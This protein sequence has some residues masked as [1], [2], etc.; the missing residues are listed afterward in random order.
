[1]L[2]LLFLI[3]N[4]LWIYL[5]GIPPK[6]VI[7]IRKWWATA[8]F[9]VPC[10]SNFRQTQVYIAFPLSIDFHLEPPRKKR[11][12]GALEE[13]WLKMGV[14]PQMAILIGK[15]CLNHQNLGAPL[16]RQTHMVHSG[17]P[18]LLHLAWWGWAA[19]C[20]KQ[21]NLQSIWGCPKLILV[22]LRTHAYM[23]SWIYRGVSYWCIL[24]VTPLNF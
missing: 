20:L 3:T 13:E 23:G 1:M 22:P 4:M 24:R 11:M 2:L 18:S 16:F 15:W 6:L 12:L 10:C 19:E 7:F 5:V 21:L 14:Y 8:V 9:E 17:W